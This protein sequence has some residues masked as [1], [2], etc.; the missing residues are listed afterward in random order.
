LVVFGLGFLTALFESLPLAM[1]LSVYL[2]DKI[3]T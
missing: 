2:V 3:L 1:N